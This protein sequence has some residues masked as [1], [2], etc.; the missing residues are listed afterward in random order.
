[1]SAPSSPVAHADPPSSARV[2]VWSALSGLGV[3][4]AGIAAT[5]A[6]CVLSWA[7]DRPSS[8]TFGGA[9]RVG[10]QVWY[11]GHGIAL[12]VSWGRVSVPP[13]LLT[14]HRASSNVVASRARASYRSRLMAPSE[15]PT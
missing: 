1:M 3:L 7:V 11:L 6:L 14:G 15:R 10:L 4:L 9:A 8:T 2:V 13:L 5:V 12:P